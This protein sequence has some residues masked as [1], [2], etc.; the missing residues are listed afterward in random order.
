M[1]SEPVRSTAVVAAPKDYSIPAA[2][3]ILLLSVRA[4]FD[5]TGAAGSFLP[6]VQILDNN[7]NVLVTAADPNV[8]VVAGASAD[9]SWFPGVKPATQT[10]AGG[11]ALLSR[12]V[13]LADAPSVT[14]SP[15]P[16]THTHI[17]LYSLTRTDRAAGSDLI[18]LQLNGDT[19]NS[20][21]WEQVFGNNG[22]SDA[23]NAPTGG[24][25]AGPISEIAL[26]SATAATATANS[27]GSGRWTVLYYT[28]TSTHKMVVGQGGVFVDDSA[29]GAVTAQMAGI[30]RNTQ[31][32]T[33]MKLF[34][35][36][37]T[38]FKA[39]SRFELYGI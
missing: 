4:S 15:I 25:I 10:T 20:Y 12:T 8:S 36:L 13:L 5:G 23:F 39:G 38:N 28:Q 22:V 6:A 31:A 26:T 21:D 7:G 1:A 9:V 24:H 19:G 17:E 2:Q 30:W 11:L 16:Q 32:V 29:A 33:A 14:I 35:A 3:Q 27:Y 34:P 37:G 18:A